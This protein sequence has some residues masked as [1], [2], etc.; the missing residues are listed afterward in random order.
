VQAQGGSLACIESGWYADRL[1]ES[2]YRYARSVDD[3]ER[4]VVGVN[5]WAS[6]AEP[7]EV[8]AADPE[9]ETRQA[10]AVRRVRAERDDTAWRS[11]M[12]RLRRDSEAGE[13]VLPACVDA[14]RAYATVGEICEVLRAVHGA[15]RPTRAF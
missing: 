4:V 5:R 15:W 13:N 7:L 12:E 10:E 2:A 14:V 6:P 8:F 1:S 9:G 11:A 3:G